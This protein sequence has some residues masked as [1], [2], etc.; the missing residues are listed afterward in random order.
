MLFQ[1]PAEQRSGG[2]KS[3][4]S[5]VYRLAGGGGGSNSGAY[6]TDCDNDLRSGGG[7]GGLFNGYFA[8]IS[9]GGGGGGESSQS[10]E[11]VRQCFLFT[12]HLLLCTRTKE[13]KLRLLEVSFELARCTT[14]IGLCACVFVRL[15]VRPLDESKHEPRLMAIALA[16][17]RLEY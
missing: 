5:S 17:T 13:G 12:N 4:L 7:G 6:A 14:T 2:S 10:R 16:R 3:R 15:F 8:S 9:G 11:L 1:V